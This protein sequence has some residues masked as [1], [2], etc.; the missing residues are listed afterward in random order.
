MKYS[1]HIVRYNPHAVPVIKCERQVLTSFSGV[2]I[3]QEL[4]ARISSLSASP[5][6]SPNKHPEV[7]MNA[8][9]RSFK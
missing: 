1:R 8:L 4:F 2:V 7:I 6:A 5:A 3:F 9:R